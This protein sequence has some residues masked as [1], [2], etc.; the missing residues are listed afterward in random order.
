[1]SINLSFP[2]PSSAALLFVPAGGVRG[3]HIP[4]LPMMEMF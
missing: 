2:C 3:I 1:M 4:N